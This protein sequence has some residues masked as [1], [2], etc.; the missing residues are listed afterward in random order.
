MATLNRTI[1]SHFLSLPTKPTTDSKT[2]NKSPITFSLSSSSLFAQSRLSL[3]SKK[4]PNSAIKSVTKDPDV[5]KVKTIDS[6]NDPKDETK[7]L[8]KGE[9]EGEKVELSDGSED[10]DRFVGRGI[11]ATI[12][13]GFGTVAITRLLTIDHDF[14]H[15]SASFFS[16][17]FPIVE[18]LFAE[19][20]SSDYHLDIKN[21]R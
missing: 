16:S 15:V 6:L 1:P 18:F 20:Q 2:H 4:R 19:F 14:W 5:V 9:G 10:F 7:V 21:L 3:N 17:S 12:V 8:I 13:L 11:N